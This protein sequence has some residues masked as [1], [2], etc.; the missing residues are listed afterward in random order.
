LQGG[1]KKLTIGIANG[2]VELYGGVPSDFYTVT[3]T[4]DNGP[5]SNKSG[6]TR[7]GVLWFTHPDGIFRYSGG[8]LPDK[9]VSDIVKGYLSGVTADS[10]AGT[11]GSKMYFTIAGNT[12]VFDQRT[13]TWNVWNGLS[14]DS[15]VKMG[16]DLYVGTSDGRVLKIGGETDNGQ[17]ISWSAT[18][19]PFTNGSAAQRQRWLKM[20]V[21][22]ELA[23]GS[24][25]NVALSTSIAGNDWTTVQT[26]TG[27]GTQIQRIIIPV[28]GFALENTVRIRFSGTGWVRLHEFTRQVRQLPFH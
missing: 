3:V 17:P 5:I 11:D 20:W 7:E 25:M 22:A 9:S 6:T 8:V 18:T 19:K 12:L 27:T 15:Y 24:S 2:I 1:L 13:G 10:V 16:D 4:E 26:V 23:A 28:P 21:M 14:P